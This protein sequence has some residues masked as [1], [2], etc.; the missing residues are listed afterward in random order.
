MPENPLALIKGES[1]DSLGFT[2]SGT[3]QYRQTVEDYARSLAERS[4]SL[5]E[6]DKAPGLA[7]EIT[8]EHVRASAHA[9]ARAFGSTPR[10]SW[11][12]AGQVG[13]YMATALAGVGGGHLDKPSGIWAFAIGVTVTVLLVVAR[14]TH[15]DRP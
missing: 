10:S 13:E 7:A 3:T 5:G 2:A 4:V 11:S 15:G 9:M 14:L 12:V 1:L 8:H 6:A